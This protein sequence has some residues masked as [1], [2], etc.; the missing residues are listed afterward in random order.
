M[1]AKSDGQAKPTHKTPD[2]GDKQTRA[3]ADLYAMELKTKSLL[4]VDNDPVNLDVFARRLEQNGYAVASASCG[5][6]ALEHLQTHGVDLI[7]LDNC[8][9][10]MTGLELL[11]EVRRAYNA[12]DLPV[13]VVTAVKDTST[14]VEALNLGAND[15]ITKPLDFNKAFAR[16]RCQLA[17]REEEHE[18]QGRDQSD[19]RAARGSNQGLWD[20]DLTTN[21][22]Y[23][24]VRWKEML[25]F[26][27]KEID[28]NPAEWFSRIHPE[29]SNAFQHELE[30]AISGSSETF[31]SEHRLRH[32]DLSWRWV[33]TRGQATRSESGRPLSLAGSVTDVTET[34]VGDPLTNL[35]NRASFT[36]RLAAALRMAGR[37]SQLAFAV[38]LLDID[39]FKVINESLGHVVGD[40]LLVGV[41]RRLR[42]IGD[43]SPAR[44]ARLGGDEFAILVDDVKT[45]QDAVSVADW[46]HGKVAKSFPLDGRDVFCSVSIGIFMGPG[47]ATTVEEILR[48]AST[49]MYRAKALGGGRYEIFDNEMRKRA[50]ERLQLETDLRQGLEHNDFEVHYQ[51]KVKLDSEEVIGFEALVRW[52]HPR[53]GLLLPADFI[54]TA[55]ET[56]LIVPLGAWVMEQA[57]RQLQIWQAEFPR[58][59]ALTMS[60]NVSCRQFRDKAFCET[61]RRVVRETNIDPHTFGLEL[62]ETVLAD[63]ADLTGPILKELHGIGVSLKIYDFGTVYSSL[64]CLCRFPFDSL[65]ID[66]SFLRE[67]AGK[68]GKEIVKSVVALAAGLGLELVAEGIETEAQAAQ[69]K[70]LGCRYAQ[71]FYFSRPMNAAA[72]GQV[73]LHGYA[74][75]TLTPVAS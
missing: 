32:K 60:V 41:A 19:A 23:Y 62:N 38:L 54:P 55:E 72:A 59:P 28:N 4:L 52:N 5:Q 18:I 12:A 37:D 3:L 9:P 40:E 11:K 10:E 35:P 24:S 29:D 21:E 27:E 2:S 15:Y 68:E 50:M 56:G 1:A 30:T 73:L 58:I 75:E 6:K 45:M 57:A 17:R 25:G 64:S 74:S 13:I 31:A 69:L 7:L 53:R 8:L 44:V 46:V 33:L 34:K 61:V 22:I 16:I 47:D 36:K 66:R 42:D 51:P 14:A 48:D 43:R 67:I 70:A 26:D 63:A 71:G 49:A 39:R 65:R 20:W